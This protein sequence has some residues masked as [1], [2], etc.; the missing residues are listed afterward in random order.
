MAKEEAAVLAEKVEAKQ[1]EEKKKEETKEEA[2]ELTEVAAKNK[3]EEQEV[4]AENAA[5][6]QAAKKQ[7]QALTE[8]AKKQV[9]KKKEAA[10]ATAKEADKTGGELVAKAKEAVRARVKQAEEQ[11]KSAGESVVK[12]AVATAN[13]DKD[14]AVQQ[15][16]KEAEQQAEENEKKKADAGL[17]KLG[18]LGTREDEL[19]EEITVEKGKVAKLRSHAKDVLDNGAEVLRRVGNIDA[20]ASSDSATEDSVAAP[21]VEP[22]TGY[23]LNTIIVYT[24]AGTNLASALALGRYYLESRSLSETKYHFL[25]E[26]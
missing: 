19:K 5:R 16:K 23:S 9:E 18:K 20:V 4:K 24:L 14:I 3:K 10:K 8:T 15:A 17:N 25:E 26:F 2:K 22:S 13:N 12:A 7:D 11:G 6:L 1:E 21:F